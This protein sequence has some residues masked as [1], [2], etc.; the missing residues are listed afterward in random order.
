MFISTFQHRIRARRFAG[1][2]GSAGAFHAARAGFTLIELMIVAVV[3]AILAAAIVPN[4]V[5]R[6]ETARRSRAQSDIAALDTALDLF[7]VNV[8]RYPTTEEGLRVLYYEPDTEVEGWKGP[9]LKKPIFE[10]PWGNEYV[11]RSPG[12]YSNQPYEIMSY[13]KDGEEGGE[14]DNADVKSW[15]ERQEDM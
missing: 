10:D 5:G 6:A 4:V 3:L 2:L 11:Y 15:V 14:E 9:Y 12:V 7:Y 13:G 8:G 1:R